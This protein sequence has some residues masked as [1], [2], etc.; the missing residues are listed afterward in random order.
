M[1]KLDQKLFNKNNERNKSR[2]FD[3]NI[4]LL[5]EMEDVKLKIDDNK[6]KK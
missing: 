5:V 1:L 4:Y 3:S 6:N 2:V